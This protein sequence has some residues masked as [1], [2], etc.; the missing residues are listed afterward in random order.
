MSVNEGVDALVTLGAVHHG[1]SRR[2]ILFGDCVKWAAERLEGEIGLVERADQGAELEFLVNVRLDVLLEQRSTLQIPLGVAWS[3]MLRERN[4][5]AETQAVED[6]LS[7][8]V[9]AQSPFPVCEGERREL[10]W[11][12]EAIHIWG[13]SEL[14]QAAA[15]S[16][17]VIIFNFRTRSTRKTVARTR[18]VRFGRIVR[19]LEVEPD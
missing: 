19:V 5:P 2:R 9:P 6:F 15:N 18:I 8:K 17:N 11:F 13:N 12:S 1:A 10:E 3:W 14:F 7:I 16:I 4:I